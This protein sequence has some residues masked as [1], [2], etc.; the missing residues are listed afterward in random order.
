MQKWNISTDTVERVNG[1]K[2][3][4]FHVYCQSFGH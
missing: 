2:L 3:S 1:K 4:G